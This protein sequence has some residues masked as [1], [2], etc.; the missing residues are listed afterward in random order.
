MNYYYYII[1]IINNVLCILALTQ[2][3]KYITYRID[4]EDGM[5][6]EVIMEWVE[7]IEIIINH[8]TIHVMK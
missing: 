5:D 7:I 3:Y 6:M 2:N 1:I 8:L 4:G